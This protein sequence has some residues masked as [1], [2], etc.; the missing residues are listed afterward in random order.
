MPSSVTR[1]LSSS[2]TTKKKTGNLSLTYF[3]SADI[4]AHWQGIVYDETM[5]LQAEQTK[6][7]LEKLE[8]TY[9]LVRTL[10][11]E[12]RNPL[13]NIGLSIEGMLDRG[14]D[15]GQMSYI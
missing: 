4:E 7:Q 6:L 14:L 3:E 12:I 15:E 11:H 9:R 2:T 13:T 10:A 8:A 1:A 5:R